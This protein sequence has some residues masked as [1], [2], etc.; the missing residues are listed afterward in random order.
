[1][2]AGGESFNYIPC[3]NNHA[4]WIEALADISLNHMQA[5][6]LSAPDPQVLAANRARALALGAKN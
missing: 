3:L 1:L 4:Q 6:D 5:W 2:H